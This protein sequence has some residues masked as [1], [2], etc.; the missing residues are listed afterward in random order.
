MAAHVRPRETPHL[1][2]LHKT[3]SLP[4]QLQLLYKIQI[5]FNLF[6]FISFLFFTSL[7]QD[8]SLHHFL[9]HLNLNHQLQKH[10]Q[11]YHLHLN[12]ATTL[13]WG[14]STSSSEISSWIISDHDLFK[15][16][17]TNPCEYIYSPRLDYFLVYL[18]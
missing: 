18:C 17:I 13:D 1:P 11:G 12:Q 14:S 16:L 10:Q 9:L 4:S 3:P 15:L 7:H 2:Y 5:L 8:I 6:L